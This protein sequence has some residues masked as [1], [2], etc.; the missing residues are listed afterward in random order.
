MA[1]KKTD[2]GDKT[3]LM[4]LSG[5][6]M[7]RITVPA[8]WKVTFGPLVPKPSG[9]DRYQ[10]KTFALRFYEGRDQQRA[11]FTDVLSFRDESLKVEERVTKTKQQVVHKDAPSGRREMVVEARVTEWRDPLAPE[12]S[13][14][15]ANFL[16]ITEAKDF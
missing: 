16:A 5:G 13:T 8:S 12:D 6:R 3:Y 11:I 15:D 2:T 14:A 10:N 7:R 1:T 9:D 4:D